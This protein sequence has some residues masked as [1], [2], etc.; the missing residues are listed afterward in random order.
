MIKTVTE[1]ITLNELKTEASLVFGDMVKAVIDVEKKVMAINGE[2]HADEEKFLLELGS[3]QKNL[4]GVNLYVDLFGDP[5]WIEFDSMI[6]LRPSQGNT[7]RGVDDQQTQE[8]IVF[9][10]NKLI[11]NK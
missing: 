8:K 2:L 4:W 5:D 10:V 6:N 3:E 9:I 7:S 11:T 1:P